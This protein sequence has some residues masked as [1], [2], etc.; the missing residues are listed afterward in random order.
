M[1]KFRFGATAFF[2]V[3]F[4]GVNALAQ[5][6]RGGI[7]VP[8]PAPDPKTLAA[9]RRVLEA[10]GASKMVQGLWPS[11][12]ET[13][14]QSQPSIPEDAWES[15]DREFR[16]FFSSDEFLS[17]I[18]TI[19]AGSFT[20]DELTQMAAFYETPLGKKIVAKMP[21]VTTQCFQLGAEAGRDLAERA[22]KR[23]KDRGYKIT[24]D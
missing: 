4:F 8:A 15:I 24:T 5:Q 13:M 10:T 17:Q 7:P 14:K 9:A 12:F 22:L 3:L 21:E 20:E 6:D 18:A 11:V 16:A 23:L 1:L 19:Y 2:L